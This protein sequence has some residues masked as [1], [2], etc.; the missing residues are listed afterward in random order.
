VATSL[1]TRGFNPRTYLA[2]YLTIKE[3][4]FRAKAL[5]VSPV[6][7]PRLKPGVSGL[8]P[9]VLI[10]PYHHLS[11]FINPRLQTGVATSL[12][13]RGFNPRTYLAGYLTIK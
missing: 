1:T 7:N 4:W 13:T 11:L 6:P 12:T 3:L 5:F 10:E 8:K 9:E 2:G